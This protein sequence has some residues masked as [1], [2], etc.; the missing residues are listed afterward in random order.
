MSVSEIFKL[1]TAHGE[2]YKIHYMQLQIHEPNA[3]LATPCV[4]NLSKKKIIA[5]SITSP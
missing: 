5:S 2:F 3:Q 1:I 4:Y